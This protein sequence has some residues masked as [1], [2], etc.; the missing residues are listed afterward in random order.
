MAPP[1]TLRLSQRDKKEL[2]KVKNGFN[3]FR[4]L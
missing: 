1:I 2:Q 4:A 3:N